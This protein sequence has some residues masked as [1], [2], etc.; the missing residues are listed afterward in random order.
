MALRCSRRTS[1]EL[2]MMGSLETSQRQRLGS[3]RW[4]PGHTLSVVILVA[5][6]SETACQN[7]SALTCQSMVDD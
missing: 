5:S 6:M 7:H 4:G 3:G 1:R 2:P